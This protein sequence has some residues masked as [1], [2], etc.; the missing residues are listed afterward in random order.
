MTT[1][2]AVS[3][4]ISALVLLV[5]ILKRAGLLDAGWEMLK[6]WLKKRQERPKPHE[7][8]IPDDWGDTKQSI[9]HTPPV[10]ELQ[11]YLDR[12]DRERARLDAEEDTVRNFLKKKEKTPS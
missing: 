8:V 12:L 2:A 4:G 11:S 6:E 7:P 5:A 1:E 3:G 10:S 9:K